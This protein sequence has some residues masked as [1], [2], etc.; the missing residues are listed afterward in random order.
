MKRTIGLLLLA[1]LVVGSSSAA[2]KNT[3]GNQKAKVAL[4]YINN[5]FA[6]YDKLQKT[7]WANPEL[8]F[9]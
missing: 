4:D 8:G 1:T 6:T 7:I 3:K 9:L 5:N 2:K